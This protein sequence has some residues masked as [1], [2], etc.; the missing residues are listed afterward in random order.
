M[1]FMNRPETEPAAVRARKRRQ[2]RCRIIYAGSAV[3]LLVIAIG[4]GWYVERTGM[5]ATALAPLEARLA[6]HAVALG[7]TVQSVEVEGRARADRQAILAALGVGRGSPILELDLTGAKARLEALPWVRSAAVERRLPDGIYVRLVEHQPVAV[8]QHHRKFD[9]IDQDGAVI[10]N[11]RAEEFPDL[12]QVVGDGAPLAAS[13]LV[14]MLASE[15]DLASRVTASVRIG[16]RRW[17]LQFDN[18]VEVA[19]P[20]ESAAAAWHRLAAL[21]RSD[22][23]LE[24]DV[25]AIDMRLD[26]R[27]VLR[28]P[29]DTAKTLIKKGR[30]TRPN[31]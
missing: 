17:N 13:D 2:A 16:E 4:G 9:L 19:L 8:W 25:T 28:L 26:D 3:G 22:K 6:A 11:A 18:G 31:A 24:R 21:E 29:A 23:V 12:P 10:P 27:L 5:L 1:R 20:E 14:D 30:P 7:L 15:G